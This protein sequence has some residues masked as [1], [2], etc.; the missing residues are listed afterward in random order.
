MPGSVRSWAPRASPSELHWAAVTFCWRV[1]LMLTAT[2][3][4]ARMA[5]LVH[6]SKLP[7][8]SFALAA[9]PR[10]GGERAGA[11]FRHGAK[12]RRPG[13]LQ[14][15]RSTRLRRMYE[16]FVSDPGRRARHRRVA[17]GPGRRARRHLRRR[18][19][20]RPS[21][22]RR[23]QLDLGDRRRLLRDVHAGGLRP[24]RDR[25]LTRQ[26]LR[27]GRREDPLELLDRR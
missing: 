26:E 6:V 15:A 24:A 8:P 2:L 18:R 19:Q 20:G 1:L 4:R 9:R 12:D 10:P 22:L 3:T 5:L 21:R 7:R 13:A 23:H 17:A 27:H 25:L 11:I 16:T 14:A